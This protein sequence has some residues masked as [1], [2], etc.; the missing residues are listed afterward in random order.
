MFVP[1]IDHGYAGVG[2]L[3]CTRFAPKNRRLGQGDE[4]A[5][6]KELVFMRT[7]GMRE[8]RVNFLH[9]PQRLAR[10]SRLANFLALRRS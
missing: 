8:N 6:S 9:W 3:V 2:Q 4:Y 5:A 7:A 10:L 1:D